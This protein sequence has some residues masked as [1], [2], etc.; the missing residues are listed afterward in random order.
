MNKSIFVFLYLVFWLNI[1]SQNDGSELI[2]RDSIYHVNLINTEIYE[3]KEDGITEII[4][5]TSYNYELNE[6]HLFWIENEKLKS[7]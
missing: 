4:C 7:A 1:Y 3:L 5:L 6:S 2:I